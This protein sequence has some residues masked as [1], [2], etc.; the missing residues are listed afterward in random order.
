LVSAKLLE[1]APPIVMPVMERLALP[2]LVTVTVWTALVVPAVAEKLSAV[3]GRRLTT[4]AGA[5]FAVP[6]SATVCGEPD[7][8]SATDSI[9]V[10]L[11]AELGEKVML[12]EQVAPAA[13]IEPQLLVSEKVLAFAPVIEIPVSDSDAV[14]ELVINTVCEA[15]VVPALAEKL[16]GPEGIRD[17]AGAV[18]AAV[19]LMEYAVAVV[20]VVVVVVATS[21]K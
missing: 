15:L 20:V 18:V 21:T 6:L 19:P 10:S 4:G 12:T 13:S 14:P 2:V 16:N 11:P 1:F 8:L 3:L 9:A 5:G 17:T 7:A